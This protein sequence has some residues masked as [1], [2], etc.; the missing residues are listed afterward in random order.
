VFEELENASGVR[1]PL[2][3]VDDHAG[4][5][6]NLDYR[7]VA[8]L[9]EDDTIELVENPDAEAIGDA[10][11]RI[12]HGEDEPLLVGEGLHA[13]SVGRVWDRWQPTRYGSREE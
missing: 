6:P 11:Y 7:P 3:N 2:E 4:D 10:G 1:F 9:D 8:R 12:A 5:P 13:H